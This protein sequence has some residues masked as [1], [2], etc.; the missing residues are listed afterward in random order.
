MSNPIVLH[1]D[2]LTQLKEA[3]ASAGTDISGVAAVDVDNKVSTLSSDVDS[4]KTTINSMKADIATLKTTVANIKAQMVAL[5]SN[6][7]LTL[8]Q[9]EDIEAPEPD[10]PTAQDNDSSAPVYTYSNGTLNINIF[11]ADSTATCKHYVYDNLHVVI[12]CATTKAFT[13]TKGGNAYDIATFSSLD[14]Y[15]GHGYIDSVLPAKSNSQNCMTT[16]IEGNKIKVISNASAD[17][18]IPATTTPR[19]WTFYWF[20]RS[21]QSKLF[22]FEDGQLISSNVSVNSPNYALHAKCGNL[23]VLSISTQMVQNVSAYS[24]ASI[25]TFN[26]NLAIPTGLHMGNAYISTPSGNNVVYRCNIE[27]PN[28]NTIAI[29][30]CYFQ[31]ERCSDET[32]PYIV[33]GAPMGSTAWDIPANAYVTINCMW[34]DGRAIEGSATVETGNTGLNT[35]DAFARRWNL[36]HLNVVQA[37]GGVTSAGTNPIN[38]AKFSAALTFPISSCD[39]RDIYNTHWEVYEQIKAGQKASSAKTYEFTEYFDVSSI[40]NSYLD[41]TDKSKLM[42]PKPE[43]ATTTTAK[44]NAIRQA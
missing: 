29:S 11:N 40:I 24:Y 43:A 3:I 41:S 14:G 38:V 19:Y 23:H 42:I 35:N 6:N 4:S 12:I 44:H 5:V 37:Y 8:E 18:N 30:P 27:S 15:T 20:D 22:E 32:Y 33:A 2:A 36:G 39:I 26:N 17:W 28:N 7:N 25:A 34:I 13:F 21:A 1:S 10:A 9:M 31:N 16:R